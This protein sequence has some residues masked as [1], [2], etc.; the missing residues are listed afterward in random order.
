MLHGKELKQEAGGGGHWKGTAGP[1]WL[2]HS[3]GEAGV[4]TDANMAINAMA[5][6]CWKKREEGVQVAG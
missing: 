1:L 4:W 3:R 2:D 5:L 6:K